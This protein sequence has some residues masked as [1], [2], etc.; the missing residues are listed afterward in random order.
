MFFL[1]I[2]IEKSSN[3][4]HMWLAGIDTLWIESDMKIMA[5]KRETFKV[6]QVHWDHPVVFC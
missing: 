3:I 2:S 1:A 5:Q 4:K 6:F